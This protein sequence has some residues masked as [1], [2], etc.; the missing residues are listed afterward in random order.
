MTTETLNSAAGARETA[1]KAVPATVLILTYNEEQNI[2]Y[3]LKSVQDWAGEII[4]V[5]SFST[6]G[7]LDICR[8][9][10][11]KIHQHAFS[12][13]GKQVNWALDNVPMAYD[14]VFQLDADEM[15]TPELG[16]ELR[17]ALTSAPPEVTGF[18]AKRRVYFL[19]R[20][21][22]HGDYYPL[23]FL[24][25]FR[26]GKA[27][28]EEFEE[29]RVMLLE[30][31]PGRLKHDFIDYNR[32]GLAFWTEKHNQWAPNFMYQLLALGGHVE[33]TEKGIE[34]S[35]FATQDQR[36]RWLTKNVYVRLPLFWRAWIHFIYRYFLRFGF[37]D[38][39]EGMVFHFLQGLW[40]RL[41]VD[42]RL[43][44]ARK[45]GWIKER[46]KAK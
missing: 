9:Y 30:G 24:R 20:W 4:V 19:G 31:K 44:E 18:F 25:V 26:K 32:K 28:N 8:R 7:T 40:Y 17:T 27:R 43:L 45:N 15:V 2:E 3:C 22:K 34:P 42:A 12:N 41:Y 46:P 38:G 5:D 39:Y 1:R 13:H 21:I 6:D 14:W 37:L 35:F 10:T 36:R 16:E 11:H 29:D 23:W 33:S